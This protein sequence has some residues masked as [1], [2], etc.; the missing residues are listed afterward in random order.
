MSRPRNAFLADA[1]TPERGRLN[2]DDR[3]S[4]KDERLALL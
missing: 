1:A 2:T 4:R 3:D